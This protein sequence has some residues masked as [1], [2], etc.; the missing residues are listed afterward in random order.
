M[1]KIEQVGVAA[2][3]GKA[4]HKGTMAA[5]REV[6]IQAVNFREEEHNK[7][8]SDLKEN[9]VHLEDK[10]TVLTK[11]NLDKDK[12]ITELRNETG[13]F[14]HQIDSSS[15]YN[16]RDN[17]KFTGIPFVQGENLVNVIKDIT[18]HIGGEVNEHDI[19]DIHRLPGQN[20]A[21]ASTNGGARAPTI[22]CRVNRRRVKYEVIDK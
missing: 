7:E 10:V 11:D 4:M 17:L 18:K 15:Q 13:E 8:V 19:S 5:L 22:I 9:M 14:K 1:A 16:R 12:V 21:N 3:G 2:N 6:F 20:E